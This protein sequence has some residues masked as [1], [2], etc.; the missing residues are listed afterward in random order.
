MKKNPFILT[1]AGL[2]FLASCAKVDSLFTPD[3]VIQ[4]TPKQ[5]HEK[6]EFFAQKPSREALR[7]GKLTTN[8]NGQAGF[9]DLIEEAKKEAAK[10]GGD[11]VLC[12]NSGVETN[13]TYVAGHTS[14]DSNANLN[15]GSNGYGNS[16]TTAHSTGPSI[17][18]TKSPWSV[19]S[20]W[21]YSPS[22]LGVR[23]DNAKIIESFHLNSDAEDAGVKIGD[24]VIGI[25]GYDIH[26]EMAVHHQRKIRPG[27]K[28]KLT[29]QRDGKR[30]EK[31]I[32]ALPN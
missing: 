15:W 24:R 31:K 25:D 8:G 5:D 2:I 22:Q 17:V 6:I 21:I 27:D 13:T 4:T 1:A 32:T 29:L 7:I 11:F 18:T 3:L 12:E 14:Y 23:L 28:V 10:L 19:F 16:K 9:N 30:I 20:V 26:D